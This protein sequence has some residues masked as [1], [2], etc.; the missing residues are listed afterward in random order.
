MEHTDVLTVVFDDGSQ[1][2]FVGARG[3]SSANGGY[4]FWVVEDGKRRDYFFPHHSY[5]CVYITEQEDFV[6]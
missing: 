5:R 6:E 1:K 3:Y 4:S 2:D